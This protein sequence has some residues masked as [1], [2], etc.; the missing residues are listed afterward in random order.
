M[1]LVGFIV[2]IYQNARSPERQTYSSSASQKI[3]RNLRN[4]KVYYLV[5]KARH[6]PVS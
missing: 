2:R 4:L 1:Q 3:S 6:L 5:Q